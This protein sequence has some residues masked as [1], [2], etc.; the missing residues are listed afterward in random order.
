MEYYTNK[1]MFGTRSFDTEKK[2]ENWSYQ[3]NLENN[4]CNG[5]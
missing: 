3:K 4:G 1:S 2:D 5:T